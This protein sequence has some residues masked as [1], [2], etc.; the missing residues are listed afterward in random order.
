MTRAASIVGIAA[1]TLIAGCGGEKE[2]GT[3]VECENAVTLWPG[4]GESAVYYRTT[5]EATFDEPDEGASISVNDGAV[6]GSTAWDGDKLVFTPDS[7]L[8]PSASYTVAVDYSCGSPSVS[9]STSEV[10]ATTTSSSLLG[11][12]YILDISSGRFLQPPDVGDILAAYL[13]QD[14]LM[15]V[16]DAT[17]SE[18]TMI[19]AI[20][21]EGSEPPAQDT[22]SPTIEFPTANFSGN[23]YFEVGPETT[24]ITVAD[25]TI[26]IEDLEVSGAFSPDGSYISGGVLAGTIDTRPLDGLLDDSGE[27][28]AIC[29][30]AGSIGVSC[31][32]CPDGEAFCLTI[33]VDSIVMTELAGGLEEIP[34]DAVCDRPECQEED[35]CQ[36]G[37][38][39]GT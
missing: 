27:G 34:E 14:I 22:C 37:G 33:Y 38:T 9:W 10:G 13:E 8:D 32:P 24:S 36:D 30:I 25:F 26:T 28:G 18:I 3:E 16:T 6:S 4:D 31:E 17:D 29:D 11:K 21:I 7:P 15:S 23:P 12:A 35:E 20:S 19:G 2:S 5:I 1:L 39:T